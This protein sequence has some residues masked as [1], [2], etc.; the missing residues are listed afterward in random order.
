MWA[1]LIGLAFAAPDAVTP[2]TPAETPEAAPAEPPAPP[3]TL[4]EIFASTA[5]AQ[6]L[7]EAITHREQGDWSGA[8]ARLAF[9]EGKGLFPQTVAFQRAVIAEL[10][11]RYAEARSRYAE[12][13]TRWPDA[14]EAGDAAYRQ[15][16]VQNDSGDPAAALKTIKALQRRSGWDE[17]DT[18]TLALERGVAELRLGKERRGIRH[19]D[20]A[21]DA[22]EGGDRLRWMRARA[23]AA[24]LSA[25]L[26]RADSLS[27]ANPKKAKDAV[28][29]RRALIT[30]ADQQRQAI[31]AL[32]EPEYV[33]DALLR[34]GD[35]ASRLYAD[36]NAAPPPRSIAEDPALFA[37][38]QGMVAQ[39]SET[40]RT[41]AFQ[42]Y[43]AGVDL[44]R[45][46]SWQGS[47]AATLQERRDALEAARAAR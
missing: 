5:P 42:Y 22:L 44:A 11:E 10:S 16:L 19:I 37:T 35:S 1:L 7:D 38:Y 6:L 3:Q 4:E 18:L 43:D 28:L 45:R 20:N 9:L 26:E 12:L 23:R 39:Q 24:L 46:L 36:V 33:L 29:E 21:L 31:V 8:D 41:V 15:A 27:V 30:Q 34:I 2:E 32:N 14:P 40:F 13:I 47:V 25:Q 17:D